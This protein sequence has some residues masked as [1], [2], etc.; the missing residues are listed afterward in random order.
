MPIKST[1]IAFIH[2]ALGR[3][4]PEAYPMNGFQV[5]LWVG[6][7]ILPQF[8]DEHV[9]AAAQEI[10]VFPPDIEQDLLSFQDAIGMFAKE[11]QQIG[12]LLGKV[13]DF[14]ADGELQIGIRKIELPDREGDCPLGMHLTRPAEKDLH[15]H[16][17]F[18]DAKGF[19]DIIIRPALKTLDLVFFHRF[20]C[21]KEDGHHI[22]LLPDLFGHRKAVFVGHH[23]IEQADGEFVLVELLDGCLSVG[24]Q[25]HLVTGVDQIVLDDISKGKVVFSQ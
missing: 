16:Q 19:G 15:P 9:H 12:F 13:E 20:G 2:S 23:Y 17:E 21:E 4:E 18:L 14:P 22:A 5:D 7:E 24:A 11:F 3:V 1:G 25:D 8:G 6:L 10:I